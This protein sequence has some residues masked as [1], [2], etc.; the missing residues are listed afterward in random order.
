ML[1][2]NS[3]IKGISKR[4]PPYK[5]TI[6]KMTL[7]KNKHTAILNALR[8]IEV[9]RENPFS[10]GDNTPQLKAVFFCPSFFDSP[11]LDSRF[12]IMMGLF[13]Q[14]LGLVVPLRGI[15]TPFNSVANTVR[16]IGVGFIKLQSNGITA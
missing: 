10:N 9:G 13:G 16:S 15:L 5:S 12:N 3:Q 4:Y 14:S 11:I 1:N 6:H 8:N 7:T 2:S